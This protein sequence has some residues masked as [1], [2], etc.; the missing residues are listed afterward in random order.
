MKP[1]FNIADYPADF[2]KFEY[3]VEMLERVMRDPYGEIPSS[4]IVAW[5]VYWCACVMQKRK[6][7][8]LN[9]MSD[10]HSFIDFFSYIRLNVGPSN[11]HCKAI[12]LS[13][14]RQYCRSVADIEIVANWKEQLPDTEQSWISL[15][16]NKPFRKFV[17]FM[18]Y[19][20]FLFRRYLHAIPTSDILR[21]Y[22]HDDSYI[23]V[24]EQLRSQPSV[25]A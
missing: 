19:P 8:Q 10:A 9:I 18:N 24:A 4:A 13:L 16:S 3:I 20:H 12:I 23:N 17:G 6:V 5:F 22:S 14:E 21:S 1:Q 7:C 25:F 15:C 2:A 11:S